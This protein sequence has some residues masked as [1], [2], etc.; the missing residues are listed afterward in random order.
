MFFSPSVLALISS[1]GEERADL[2][3]SRA[4]V[5]LS[6]MRHVFSCFVFL[7][8]LGACLSCQRF[9]HRA[10]RFL[11]SEVG[12]GLFLCHSRDFSF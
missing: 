7:V 10:R 2:Y 5:S 9:P 11:V 3:A 8:E 4:F 12:Y 6:C 1:F